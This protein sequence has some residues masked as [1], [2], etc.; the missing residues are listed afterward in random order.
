MPPSQEEQIRALDAAAAAAEDVDA[1]CRVTVGRAAEV[2]DTAAALI[3]TGSGRFRV[4]A[5]APLPSANERAMS[6]A[7]QVWRAAAS[8][9]EAVFV[10]VDAHGQ[11]WT[12]LVLPT[13]RPTGSVLMLSGDWTKSR[14][15]LDD[16]AR[17]LGAAFDRVAVR[18]AE[19]E[20]ERA[21]RRGTFDRGLAA[22]HVLPRRLARATEPA[23]IHQAIVDACAAGVRARNASMAL[24]DAERRSLSIAATRGYP[25]TL[26]RHLRIRPG[27][28][29]IGS[30][31]RTG[32]ALHV[33]DV[34]R[35]D[36]VTPRLRYR[37]TAFIS[38]PVN[39][40]SH[41]LGV[42]NVS[43]PHGA[44]QF[45]RHDLRTLRTL[46]SIARLAL[47]RASAIAQADAA[48]HA[49]AVDP[50]TGLFNRRHFLIRLDEEVERAKR[51]G[52]PLTVM[53]LDVDN[54]K[55]LNDRHG[56]LMG[57]AVLRSVGDVLRRSIR[58][59]DVCAR[60]GGDEF[61]ILMP[62]TGPA[63]SR[64]IAE[65]IR[66]G[67][68]DA[69]PVGGSSSGDLRLSTSIGIATFIDDTS[70]DLLDRADQAL[71]AAKREGKNRI[72]I[73]PEN[74]EDLENPEAREP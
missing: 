32:R 24:Y 13:R 68:E 69:R 40:S 23:R 22:V 11:P 67:V 60:Q 12:C 36:G 30:V 51:Q 33:D 29:I 54:F 28:G 58:L 39:G 63:S 41:V 21:T 64:Q 49:A 14:A 74:P 55:Q 31:F 15:V 37:T 25:S 2:L 50:L 62:G 72:R 38:V 52:S 47:D 57:D 6:L 4:A 27:D 34:R 65:R 5:A 16:S 56:H 45:S 53:M 17:R 48:A 59:F 19:Q 26:V 9:T 61:A 18:C 20:P 46:A 35:L 66:E 42:L 3:E 70:E 10:V 71:Y 8:A 43:D 44:E 1:A 7:E 73:A